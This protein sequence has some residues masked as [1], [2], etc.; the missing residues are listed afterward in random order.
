MADVRAVDVALVLMI[1]LALFLCGI[2]ASQQAH[3]NQLE[4]YDDTP[5]PVHCESN[6]R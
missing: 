6:G 4:H 1:F 5:T 3:I 2:I